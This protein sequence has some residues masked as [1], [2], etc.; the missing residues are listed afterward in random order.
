MADM[1]RCARAPS[2]LACV[3]H[4]DLLRGR[5]LSAGLPWVRQGTHNH[6]ICWAEGALTQQALLRDIM[7]YCFHFLLSGYL[8]QQSPSHDIHTKN[9]VRSR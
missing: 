8:G 9:E 4:K 3:D 1:L 6:S 5:S 7:R 2:R